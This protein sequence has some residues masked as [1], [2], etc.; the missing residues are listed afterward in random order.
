MTSF[1]LLA[2]LSQKFCSTKPS[3]FTACVQRAFITDD[4]FITDAN[5][6]PLCNESRIAVDIVDSNG[7][8]VVYNSTT[9]EKFYITDTNGMPINDYP[10]QSTICKN[11]EFFTTI[12]DQN[13]FPV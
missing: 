6:S 7:F 11:K 10:V 1:K 3:T 13:G 5:G 9:Y 4:F 12:T 2:R 8:P